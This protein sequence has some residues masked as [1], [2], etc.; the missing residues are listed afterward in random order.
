MSPLRKPIAELRFTTND[1]AL[2]PDDGKVR[3]LIEGELTV[4][5]QPH[6][7]HQYA[8]TKLLQSLENWN[9]QTGAG[10]ANGAPGLIFSIFDAVAPDRVWVSTE[11]LAEILGDDGK[12]HGAP[13]LVIEVISPGWQN[14]TRDR[15]TK[16]KLYS[17]QGM[18]E[19]WIVDWQAKRIEV[20]R[21][22]RMRLTQMLTWL[23]EDD[24]T[25][26][27]LPGFACKVE[28]LFLQIPKQF[29]PQPKP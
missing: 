27:L 24:I 15:D 1:L 8:C 14:E 29:R 18:R 10:Y 7:H 2:M 4:S 22:Q 3:E 16:L 12:L 20:F 13:E 19:Y 6:W 23:N 21:R 9:E 26:P 25:S 11:R 17:R 5:T 28:R